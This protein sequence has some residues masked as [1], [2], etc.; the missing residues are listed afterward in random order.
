MLVIDY[1]VPG[2]VCFRTDTLRVPRLVTLTELADLLVEVQTA[3][4]SEVYVSPHWL[5]ESSLTALR[6]AI[7]RCHHC[8][9]PSATTFKNER[10]CRGH[11]QQLREVMHA[12]SRSLPSRF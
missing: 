5:D 12:A 1:A 2:A 9:E 7:P 8:Q 3:P 11:Q 4:T 6:D 10:L